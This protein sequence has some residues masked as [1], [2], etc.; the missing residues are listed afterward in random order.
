MLLCTT[1]KDL[2][3]NFQET[4]K[5]KQKEKAALAEYFNKGSLIKSSSKDKIK[6]VYPSRLIISKETK[7][8]KR[9]IKL[10]KDKIKMWE[11]VKK[12]AKNYIKKLKVKRFFDKT[13][14]KHTYKK[15]TDKEYKENFNKIKLSPELI[16]DPKLKKILQEF[17]T[18]ESFREKLVKTMDESIVY[19]EK[20]LGGQIVASIEIKDHI[21]G[22][23]LKLLK[24][25]L[26]KLEA[27]LCAYKLLLKWA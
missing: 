20:G 24:S 2:E 3:K 16:V 22:K 25:S 5:L 17:M 15:F 6:I 21:A 23:K 13:Y 10:I 18:N 4:K 7:E 11:K 8:L 1:Y 19:K 26:N 9:Q 12:D 27:Y 14:W